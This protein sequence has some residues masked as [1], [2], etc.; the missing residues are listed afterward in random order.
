MTP[1]L[2]RL[3]MAGVLERGADPDDRSRI[4]LALTERGHLL[5]RRVNRQLH[6]WEADLDAAGLHHGCH[7]AGT[8]HTA[9]WFEDSTAITSSSSHCR[10]WI[11]ALPGARR[12]TPPW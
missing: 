8:A 7:S 6:D 5:V 9:S 1:T 12:G 10:S 3:E 2:D 4:T 11:P